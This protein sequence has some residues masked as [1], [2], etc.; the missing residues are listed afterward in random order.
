MQRRGFFFMLIRLV[1]QLTVIDR[2]FLFVLGFLFF[3]R[4][5]FSVLF[6][7]VC[8]LCRRSVRR[9]GRGDF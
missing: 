8:L 4:S 6:R 9:V 3:F 5:F 7:F 2:F 1:R